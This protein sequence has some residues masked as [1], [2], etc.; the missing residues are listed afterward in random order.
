MEAVVAAPSASDIHLPFTL[1]SL[2]PYRSFSY[3]V[4]IFTHLCVV[5]HLGLLGY[6]ASTS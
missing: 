5:K 4:F 2:S 1:S 6:Q 3:I